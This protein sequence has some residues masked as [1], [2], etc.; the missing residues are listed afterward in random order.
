MYM[1]SRIHCAVNAYGVLAAAT[2]F[3]REV[4]NLEKN[5]LAH[6]VTPAECEQ[7]VFNRP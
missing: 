2:G 7:V 6:R 1:L 3:Y 5:W 4:G